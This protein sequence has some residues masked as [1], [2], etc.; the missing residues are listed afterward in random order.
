MSEL[1]WDDVIK[2]VT[3]ALDSDP[4]YCRV[5]LRDLL[6]DLKPPEPPTLEERVEKLE[7]IFM[8]LVCG[9]NEYR[10][11]TAA[12]IIHDREYKE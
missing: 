5:I 7:S 10:S 8:E 11:W 2:R 9:I 12:Q 1:T 4:H 6:V 3:K